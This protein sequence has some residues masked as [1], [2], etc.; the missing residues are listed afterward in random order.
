MEESDIVVFEAALGSDLYRQALL[1]REAVLRR[2]LGLT[3]TAEELADD[4]TRQHFCAIR[5]GRAGMA[6]PPT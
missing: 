3:I 1:L 6:S 2:P 5:F 4:E